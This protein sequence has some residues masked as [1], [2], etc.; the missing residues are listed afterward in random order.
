MNELFNA[1]PYLLPRAALSHL[2]AG[3]LSRGLDVWGSTGARDVLH[4][5]HSP[6]PSLTR[7]TSSTRAGMRYGS[8]Q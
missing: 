1:Y 5:S 3:F 8:V 4:V 6:F 7:H 2:A